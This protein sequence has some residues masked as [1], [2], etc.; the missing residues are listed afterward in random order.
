MGE[1][2]PAREVEIKPRVSGE[3]IEVSNEFL[4]GGFFSANQIM[5]SIDHTDYELVVRQL[6]SDVAKT[7]SDLAM[8]MGNQRIA[9]RELTLLGEKVSKEEEALIL[10][11][12]Q[13]EKLYATK[14]LPNQNLPRH[15]S[16]WRE[17]I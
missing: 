11:K 2:I 5:V 16:T 14:T 3:I 8:E 1:I 13:L 4:P 7:E 6:E 10:R 17:L 12:P 15:G 9:Q